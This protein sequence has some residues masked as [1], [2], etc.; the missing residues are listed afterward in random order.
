ML[1]D[2]FRTLGLAAVIAATAAFATTH[3]YAAE[4]ASGGQAERLYTRIRQDPERLAIFLRAFPKG[5]DLHNHLAGAIYA[6]PMLAWAARDGLCVRPNTGTIGTCD[7]GSTPATDLPTSEA[8]TNAMIDALSMRDFVP[9]ATDRSGHDHFFATFAKFQAAQI[10]HQGDMLTEAVQTAARDNVHLIELMITP[11][12][13]AIADVARTHALAGEN[14]QATADSLIPALAPVIAAARADV[15]SMETTRRRALGCDTD[16]P[17]DGC[18]VTVRYLFQTIRV[19]PPAFVFAQIATGYALAQQDPRFVGV[20]I[21]APE[22][23]P[24]AMRDYDLHMRMFHFFGQQ[25]PEIHLS[26][27]AGELTPGLVP[28]DGLR[29]HIR[30][31]IEVANASR[32]GHGIDIA[33][34]DDAPGL[35]NL[36]AQR[37]T[38]VEINLTS[39]DVILGVRGADHPF[40]LYR[41][42]HV[43][44]A[45]STDDE[46]VSR[47]DLTHEYLRAVTTWPLRYDELLDLSRASLQYSFLP[48]DALFSPTTPL[49]RAAACRTDQAGSPHPSPSCAA[50]LSH[51]EKAR[52]QWAL[53]ADFARFDRTPPAL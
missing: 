33:Q 35:L 3:T 26:L 41:A 15:D 49:T 28:P 23:D 8:A 20:N 1:P 42:A 34:E 37:H 36:M 27:H 47:I 4:G 19:M 22:D 14:F 48:G 16:H 6:E 53:E 21:V 44:V 50:L 31:A 25:H 17:K 52:A 18:A 24:V 45:L 32:I 7:A 12:F 9:T 46:G 29:S 11:Q 40:A 43:P 39:N 13:G 30:N 10:R 2:R 51:S 5:A 38:L